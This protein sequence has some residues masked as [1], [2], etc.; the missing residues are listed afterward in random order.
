MNAKRILLIILLGYLPVSVM[1]LTLSQ[2]PL[3]IAS[4]EPNIML[5]ASRDHQL[6]IKAYTDYTDIDAN[7]T[8]DTTYNDTISYYGYF[9]PNKCYN[10]S[11]A[12]TRFE[13]ST[14]VTITAGTHQCPGGT[15]WSGNFMNW[16][17]MTRMD[18]LR[19]TFYGGYR[20]TD[21]LTETV[22]E[23]HFLTID[24]H[25]FVKVFNPGSSATLSFYMPST[26]VGTNTA[27]SLC[28]VTDT[29]STTL[30][31]QMSFPLAAPLIKVAAST[32]PQ[33]DASEVNECQ[34]SSTSSTSPSSIPTNNTATQPQSLLGTYI[35]RVKVCD[36]TAIGGV[37]SNCKTYTHPTTG[38]QTIK[39]VGLLQQY[40]DVNADRR[41]RFGLM[42]GSYAANKS[43]GVLRK[44]VGL[45]TNNQNFPVTSSSVCGV[46]TVDSDPNTP[47]PTNDEIDVCTGQF[48]NQAANQ[49]GIINTLNRLHIAGFK[50][51]SGGNGKHQYACDQPGIPSSGLG[52]PYVSLNDGEC[53]DWGN[54][55]SEIYLESLRYFTMSAAPTSVFD[56]WI[57]PA[58]TTESASPIETAIL[59]SI[60]KLSWVDPLPDTKW[61]ALSS[62]IVLSTGLNSFDTDQLSSF[63]AGTT[64]VDANTLTHTVGDSSHENIN[65]GSYLIGNLI[66]GSGAS[67]NNVCTAKTSV[68]LDKAKGV[69]PELPSTEGGYGIAGLAYAPK[70]IDLRPG[71]LDK[72]TARWGGLNPI[73]EDWALRQPINTYTVQLAESLPS[74]TVNVNSGSVTFLPACQANSTGSTSAWTASS[75]GWRNCSMTNL[76]VDDNVPFSGTGSVGSDTT[77]KTKSCSGNGTT[78][79][80]F[81][82]SWEDST[83]GNDYDMDGIQRLGYCIGTACDTFKMLCPTTSSANATIGATAGWTTGSTGANQIR[84]VTCAVQA[85]AGHALTF[86]YTVTGTSADGASFPILRPGGAN[87][88]VGSALASGI[89]APNSI[90]FT[91]GSSAAKLLKNPLWYAAKYGGFTESDPLGTPNPDQLSEWDTKNNLTGNPGPDG[92][93]DNYF[94]IR[95]PANLITALSNVFD[96]AS[97]PDASA[98][99]VA[100]NSTNLRVESRIFQAK[101][102]SADWSGQL[103][104]YKIDTNGVLDTNA[105]WDA[106]KIINTQSPINSG[107]SNDRVILTKGATDG[108]VFDYT[109]LTGAEQS[110][111]DTN[112]AGTVD[113]CGLERTYYLRGDSTYEGAA[114]TFHCSNSS[115]STTK[116]AKFRQRRSSV[117]GDIVNSNPWYVGPPAA[118]LSDLDNPGYSAFKTA[119]QSRKAVVYAGGNDGMLHGFDA[120]LDFSSNTTGV[121]TA[122]AGQEIVAYIP[123]EVYPNLSKLTDST[124][125]KNH[126]YL[127]DGSPMT[128]DADVDSSAS[129][130][131]RTVLIAGLGA[132]GHGYYALDVSDPASFSEAGSAPANTLLWEFNETDMG[133]AYNE[134][135]TS[136]VT[137]QA[138]QIVKMANGK[139]AVILGNGYNSVA[140][141][142]VLYIVFIEGG[143]DGIWTAGTDYVKIVADAPA[144]LDNGLSTPTPFD[145]D[146]DGFVDTVYAGDLKGN[147]WK[148]LVGSTPN[149]TQSENRLR[150]VTNN[151]FVPLP[152]TWQVAFS[153]AG[154]TTCTPLFKA[155]DSGGLAQPIIYPPEVT[156]HPNGGQLVLFGTGKYL[157][158]SDIA[159]TASQTFYGI[160]DRHNWSSAAAIKNVGTRT[161]AGLLLQQ[162]ITSPL[163]T[164]VGDFR[165]ISTNPITW[166]LESCAS[167]CAT[168]KMGWYIDLPTSMERS[169]GVPKL[170]NKVIFFNTLIPSQIPCDGGGTGWLMSLD[171]LTGGLVTSRQIF[172]TNGGGQIDSTDT[173]VGGFKIGAVLGG[174]T[175]IQNLLQN[176]GNIGVGVSA[177]TTGNLDVRPINFGLGNKGRMSW[178]EILQQ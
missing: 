1:A 114:G 3:F 48:I 62:I 108:I 63:T 144:G 143:I 20:S 8:L 55:I 115:P 145:S 118:G 84:I 74:F 7:G 45:I 167:P 34:L 147:L 57:R 152:T 140:G 101:F 53:V 156:S 151:P 153:A 130:D 90:I 64:T 2:S 178:R 16:A 39:P 117:L 126:R 100:T 80:C 30:T 119:K 82:I 97:Q 12:N 76:R 138:K 128:G 129:N 73:N 158:S 148:F 171:Y 15:T 33:W 56:A 96:R 22:L 106:G 160:W 86:G 26:V 58:P 87:F 24:I 109:L 61:C 146:N 42:T 65:G 81:T 77:A 99:S 122:T 159:N 11:A 67:A 23:R 69:C 46:Q 44:N 25:A 173:S 102:S 131:W 142:A 36:S 163:T 139:W 164:V 161:T 43:G 60:P 133:Y 135:A 72:R 66:G 175:L 95:N 75:T 29:T 116:I 51:T 54:P 113:N 47:S 123:S 125:N 168:G 59:P 103:L 127:V 28:N 107:S 120:S 83:W 79:R 71:Y 85:Q 154:C 52:A 98:A 172:D 19:K 18:V 4:T 68:D 149:K 134:P 89:T 111:L 41:A 32:W 170:I 94:N 93:P 37:E 49:N 157:E 150:N 10:Y 141:K 40:G 169:I 165:I 88:N 31:G 177:M 38:V 137:N 166:P 70:T 174:T 27:M 78:S 14:T 124:Y 136:L 110:L 92:D 5:V 35:A 112:A 104:S 155:T 91:Q 6:S 105:E 9:D 50:Y 176:T 13:P 121:P 17:T 132:G 21:S 162:T